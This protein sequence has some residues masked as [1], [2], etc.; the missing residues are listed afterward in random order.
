MQ[1]RQYR[2]MTPKK[3]ILERNSKECAAS[4]AAAEQQ[5]VSKMLRMSNKKKPLKK[6]IRKVASKH[7]EEEEAIDDEME[8]DEAAAEEAA[9]IKAAM[10]ENNTMTLEQ[11]TEIVL[12]SEGMTAAEPMQR[13]LPVVIER[14]NSSAASSSAMEE[15]NNKKPAAAASAASAS[16]MVANLIQNNNDLIVEV[17][18]MRPKPVVLSPRQPPGSHLLPY[19]HN[20]NPSLSSSVVVSVKP[21]LSSKSVPSSSPPPPPTT[22][23]AAHPMPPNK[24]P[25]I[26]RMVEEW[27]SKMQPPITEQGPSS[28]APTTTT[29]ALNLSTKTHSLGVTR[30]NSGSIATAKTTQVYLRPIT[31]PPKLSS[32]TS[33]SSGGGSS[34]VTISPK[35]QYNTSLEKRA[36]LPPPM[37]PLQQQRYSPAFDRFV[38]NS[39]SRLSPPRL[40]I[41]KVDQLQQQPGR[42]QMQQTV[43]KQVGRATPFENNM[44]LESVKARAL[45]DV[46]LAHT[47]DMHGNL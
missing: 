11:F 36:P 23:A 39:S 6:R 7:E 29:E 21:R 43:K 46:Q 45:R 24:P 38:S 9:K 40:E 17:K 2:K 4:A 41:K 25:N 30:G 8:V 15:N 18:P 3:R 16:E 20:P 27:F 19:Q 35:Q 5:P 44:Q 31:M 28:T 34:S 14:R 13:R 12:A 1:L 47:K 22:S 42:Q 33:T 37:P 10:A 32:P 26:P